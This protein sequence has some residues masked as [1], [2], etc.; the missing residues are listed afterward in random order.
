MALNHSMDI[1]KSRVYGE[2]IPGANNGDYEAARK[3]GDYFS[4][5]EEYDKAIQYY[6]QYLRTKN[7]LII[8]MKVVDLKAKR[9]FR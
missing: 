6:E 2:Y 7:D 9:L 1:M 8:K 3:C 5:I 4:L